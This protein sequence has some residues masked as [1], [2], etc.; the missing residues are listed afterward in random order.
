MRHQSYLY[1]FKRWLIGLLW[2]AEDALRDCADEH[3]PTPCIFGCGRMAP[4]GQAVCG[5]CAQQELYA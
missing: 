2:R 4:T 5:T 3:V 1:R